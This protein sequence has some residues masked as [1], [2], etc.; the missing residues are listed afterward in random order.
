MNIE[1]K[2]R[3]DG[4]EIIAPVD[5]S[6]I[7]NLAS[8]IS[9]KLCK[10]FPELRLNYNNLYEK[11]STLS[12]Y[13]VSLPEGMAEANYLYKNDSIYLRFGLDDKDIEKYVTH[14]CLHYLQTSKDKN[15][16]LLRLGL[17][18]LSGY[19]IHGL[20]LN[21][22]SVQYMTSKLQN[23]KSDTVKYYGIS[24]STCSPLIYP[25]LC[26]LVSQMAY[27]TSEQT[28]FNSTLFSNNNF[29]D[30]FCEL[31]GEKCYKQ[32]EKNFDRILYSE[33]KVIQLTNA[34]CNVDD[35]KTSNINSKIEKEKSFIKTTYLET[36]KLIYTS[37]FNNTYKL[38][39]N[40][41][42]IANF[43]RKLFNFKPLL[44]TVE[45]DS[46][47]DDFYLDMMIKLDKKDDLLVN[48]TYLTTIPQK[49]KLSILLENIVKLFIPSKKHNG[50]EDNL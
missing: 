5:Y 2:L 42:S 36:Q 37:Y 15:E 18:D 50:Q 41:D 32:I 7:E 8:S 23:E 30:K 47:F 31:C 40:K 29:K 35:K 21:E 14:E 9:T 33:E 39:F 6:V 16:N 28:L 1:K 12:M 13:F 26:S 4:I 25:V 27:F 46:A 22:A 11:L 45:N 19:K 48:S 38:L 24:F 43:R 10:S 44:G 17:C 34:L 49:S 3:K 20:G